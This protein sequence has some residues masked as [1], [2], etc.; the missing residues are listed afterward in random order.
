MKSRS[1]SQSNHARN[2]VGA[3]WLEVVLCISIDV[4]W[5]IGEIQSLSIASKT[6]LDCLGK[7]LDHV[8]VTLRSATLP[9]IL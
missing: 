8:T 4:L 1:L 9:K 7:A 2:R 3:M 5:N 6:R